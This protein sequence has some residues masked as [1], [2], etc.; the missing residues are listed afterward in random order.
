MAV[1]M[2]RHAT[3]QRRSAIHCGW[4][5]RTSNSVAS[6]TS[7]SVPTDMDQGP[8]LRT[9]RYM[10]KSA[11][12]ITSPDSAHTIYARL[13]TSASNVYTLQLQRVV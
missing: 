4:S 5:P 9:D 11:Q 8:G 2:P 3:A 1:K 10:L 6:S 12:Q 7:A 13:N